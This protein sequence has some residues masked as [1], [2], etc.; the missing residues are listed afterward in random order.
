MAKVLPYPYP[1]SLSKN[2]LMSK[3]ITHYEQ[4]DDI[5][6]V[7]EI[8]NN[9]LRDWR[10]AQPDNFF[11]ADRDFQRKLELYFGEQG[12]RK[13]M[14]R[15]YKFGKVVASQ[16][17][18]L[19]R[20]T[21]EDDQ[22]PVASGDDELVRYTDAYH[23]IGR[24]IY[25]S[26]MMGL[27][28]EKGNHRL[29]LSLFYLS[30]QNGE[31]GHNCPLTGT[32]GVIKTLQNVAPEGL[33]EKY[34]PLL[35]DANYETNFIGA[36]YFTEVQGGSD[37]GA[38]A[39]QATPEDTGSDVWYL[40]GQKWFCSNIT[41]DV[42]LVT[43][44]DNTAEGTAGLG[45]FLV[46]RRLADG[47]NN[48]IELEKLK[49]KLGTRSLATAEATFKDSVAYRVGNFK[50]GLDH[51]INTSR[52][53][54]AFGCIGNARRALTIAWTY[55]K[56][57]FAFGVPLMH[58]PIIQAQLAH[59]RIDVAAMLAG[60]MRITK[61]MDDVELGRATD[62][63]RKFLRMAIHLNKFRTAILAHEDIN[64][65]IEILGGNGTIEDFSVL[66]RLL[67]DN[68]VYENWEGSH[69]VLLAQILR[70]MHRYQHHV[71]FLNMIRTLL[72]AARLPEL[73]Q[74]GQHQ[75]DRISDEINEVLAMDQLTAGIYMR[76]LMCR[77]T[78]LYYTACLAAESGWEIS[79]KE[80]KSKQR[81]AILFL[82]RRVNR[83]DP[84]DVAYYDDQV[85]RIS[86]EI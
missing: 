17:D 18:P 24:L 71:P 42:A 64:T 1:L 41:A 15:L 46:P 4:P 72:R 9:R 57:R 28:G 49:Y 16:I 40:N 31:A 11:T 34:L 78:D 76:P 35:L 68:V 59:I 12:Y 81:I 7:Q 80:D 43:A 5:L 27:L 20:R 66:P 39:V 58:Y 26:G 86:S 54:N 36:Q 84:G 32:A 74:E 69:N 47:S 30:A 38:N 53:F 22:L 67:R 77:L 79:K 65:A 23:E 82:N 21:N 75:L 73:K 70:D 44:R 85:S 61:V 29:A 14:P 55:A 10:E 51:L 3:K 50:D 25:G 13:I 2:S 60:S 56:H 19:A 63:D 6:N 8:A 83:R 45:L 52:V 37:V 62:D 33:Q 48:G